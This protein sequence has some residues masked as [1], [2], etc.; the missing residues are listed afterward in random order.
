MTPR[1]LTDELMRLSRLL[2]EANRAMRD[3]GR[4]QAEHERDY[5]KARALAWLQAGGTAQERKDA[6]DAATA[7]A[8]Y[9][10]DLS[11]ADHR[12]ALEAVRNLRTQMSVLQTIAG[13]E[14]ETAGIGRTGP[15]VQP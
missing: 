7:D 10:R 3:R 11:E 15:Q 8:R 5:R 2:D 12:S 9:E 6:V 13:L 14:R 1:E 4:A